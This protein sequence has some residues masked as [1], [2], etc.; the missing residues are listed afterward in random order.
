MISPPGSVVAHR[1]AAARFAQ[2]CPLCA[3]SVIVP[4]GQDPDVV[5][6]RQGMGR[7]L[8]S[9]KGGALSPILQQLSHAALAAACGPHI[10]APPCPACR[11]QA[12]TVGV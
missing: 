3:R 4:P 6:D 11:P 7:A 10:S 2:V 12:H 8:H 9:K 5:F 1:S